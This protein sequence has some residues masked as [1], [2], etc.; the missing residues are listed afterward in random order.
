MAASGSSWRDSGP[1]QVRQV[2][3]LGDGVVRQAGDALL[4][5]DQVGQQE[6]PVGGG[7][8]RQPPCRLLHVGD[9]LLLGALV[10]R[11]DVLGERG[12]AVAGVVLR[13][14]H[15]SHV[16]GFDV[17]DDRHVVVGVLEDRG[18][19]RGRELELVEG[20][21]E[22]GLLQ[23]ALDHLAA[24]R[25]VGQRGQPEPEVHAGLAGRLPAAPWPWPRRAGTCR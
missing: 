11:G 17:R 14:E 2:E 1:G 3:R 7:V 19:P 12:V 5:H 8:L 18:Q 24:G 4:R 9:L 15:R 25:G 6:Q 16:T 22:A 10:G 21:L 20:D 13:V 23:L